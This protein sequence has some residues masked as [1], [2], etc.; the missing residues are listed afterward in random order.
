M[1][2]VNEIFL[3]CIWFHIFT[4]NTLVFDSIIL[5]NV[6]HKL[7][8][9]WCVWVSSSADMIRR[10]SIKKGFLD[11][12]QKNQSCG[13]KICICGKLVFFSIDYCF[14]KKLA[15]NIK[16]VLTWYFIKDKWFVKKECSNILYLTLNM[17]SSL[18]DE[19]IMKI[20]PSPL[21]PYFKKK[22]FEYL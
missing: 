3:L 19:R 14:S 17:I 9:S 18:K 7:L 1:Q 15:I 20:R 21:E 2:T 11:N 16:L 8:P 4:R 10:S 6:K 5:L 12:L 13:S 22:C